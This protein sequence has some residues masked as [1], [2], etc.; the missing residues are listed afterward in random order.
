MTTTA[1]LGNMAGLALEEGFPAGIRVLVI[2]DDKISVKV[3][4]IMLKK[5]G[6]KG[7]FSIVD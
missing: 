3:S 5:C 2:D 6:Y 4:C 1:E 7:E